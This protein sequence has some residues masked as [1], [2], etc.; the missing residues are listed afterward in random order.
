MTSLRP[1][2][3]SLICGFWSLSLT[4]RYWAVCARYTSPGFCGSERANA[5]VAPSFEK[6]APDITPLLSETCFGVPPLAGTEKSCDVVRVD[7]VNQSVRPSGDQVA[8]PGW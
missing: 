1:R 3:S 5:M 2:A 7:A 6:L 8:G 4:G